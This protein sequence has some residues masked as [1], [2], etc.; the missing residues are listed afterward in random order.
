[1]FTAEKDLL[2]QRRHICLKIP[3]NR[4]V[5]IIF[6]QLRLPQPWLLVSL[7]Q[8]ILEGQGRE[9]TGRMSDVSAARRR[10]G[11]GVAS[12]PGVAHGHAEFLPMLGGRLV[13][14]RLVINIQPPLPGSRVIVTG[15]RYDAVQTTSTRGEHLSW[16]DGESD[17]FKLGSIPISSDSVISYLV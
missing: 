8:A 9:Q 12:W 1:M 14:G 3:N 5:P 15:L 4:F 11:G 2:Q 7:E 6:R 17:S 13:Q 16:S 10:R